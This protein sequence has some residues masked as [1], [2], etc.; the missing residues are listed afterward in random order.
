MAECRLGYSISGLK[1]YKETRGT[2][3]KDHNWALVVKRFDT[4]IN[5]KSDGQS[6]KIYVHDMDPLTVKTFSENE[7]RE[8]NP[9]PTIWKPSKGMKGQIIIFIPA[10]LNSSSGK[11]L[12][13]PDNIEFGTISLLDLNQEVNK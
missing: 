5:S 8:N 1:T 3:L 4:V 9:N 7:V 12:K 2:F 10:I 6:L 11:N 13:L